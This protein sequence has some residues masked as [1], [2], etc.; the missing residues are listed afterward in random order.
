MHCYVVCIAHY[1]ELNWQI[2]NFAQI[3]CICRDNSKYAPDE[4]FSH[5]ERLPISATLVSD[6]YYF[7][8]HIII[9]PM[10]LKLISLKKLKPKRIGSL[11]IIFSFQ[12]SA[13][14][15]CPIV[16]VSRKPL[17]LNPQQ[18][19]AQLANT[20]EKRRK[21]KTWFQGS[22]TSANPATTLSA[23][24]SPNIDRSIDHLKIVL[25]L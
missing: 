19:R 1:T 17:S 10:W 7:V 8:E 21:Y 3:W 14:L 24:V 6:K 22:P 16:Y 13:F 20:E 9:L 23:A 18:W 12:C 2:C 4:N 11:I 15:L 5:A 25:C